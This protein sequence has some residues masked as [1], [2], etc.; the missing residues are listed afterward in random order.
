MN[1]LIIR[2]SSPILKFT[3]SIACQECTSLEK[4]IYLESDIL[5]HKNMYLELYKDNKLHSLIL[6]IQDGP[7]P[8][9]HF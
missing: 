4:A 3:H 1:T 7:F 6:V 5:K 2:T 8:F 9:V